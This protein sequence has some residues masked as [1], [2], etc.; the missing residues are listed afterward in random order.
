[1]GSTL[2]LTNLQGLTSGNDANTV[3]VPSGH[4]LHAPGHVIQTVSA[5]FTDLQT[6]TNSTTLVNTTLTGTIT[7]KF[8]TSKILV[9]I[10]TQ[11]HT[12][13]SGDYGLYGLK[14]GTT[15]LESGRSFATQKNDDWET[16]SFSY[17]D[18]P[19][20]T[21]ATTYTLT[22]KSYAGSNYVY[23]GWGTSTGGSVQNMI[24]QE[25]AQ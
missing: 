25:I 12:S 17:L 3:K 1:M 2:S 4:T 11:G 9:T 19:A 15:N 21:S 20:T 13:S 14:R 5:V 8:S 22:M 6:Y 10:S 24:L 16:I 23:H 18:S 7:P